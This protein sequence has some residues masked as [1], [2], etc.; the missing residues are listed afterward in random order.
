MFGPVWGWVKPRVPIYSLRPEIRAVRPKLSPLFFTLYE[1]QRKHAVDDSFKPSL[2]P[3]NDESYE[4]I[5]R[6]LYFC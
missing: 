5:R 4:Y 6:T 1:H 3:I 2:I